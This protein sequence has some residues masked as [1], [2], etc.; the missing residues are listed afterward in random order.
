[1]KYKVKASQSVSKGSGNIKHNKREQDIPTKNI[2]RD[3]S[4]FNVTLID[5]PIKEV[6]HMVFDESVRAYN[7][8][9]KRND[10]KINDYYTKINND[11]KTK[12][13]QELV[14]QVGNR[15]EKL[16]MKTYNQ[17]YEDFLN[18]FNN[19]NPQ[20]CVFGAYIHHDEPN[21]TP[22]L[23]LDYIPVAEYDKGMSKRVA[24][25]RAIRQM[26][27]SDWREWKDR[28]FDL[29]EEV[30]QKHDIQR[31]NMGNKERHMPL[32]V[33]RQLQREKERVREE[34]RKEVLEDTEHMKT[35]LEVKKTVFGKE[36][37]ETD[38]VNDK[39]KALENENELY[40]AQIS[41]LTNEKEKLEKEYKK[42]K[43]KRYVQKNKLLEEINE[44][45]R[46][47]NNKLK[48]E[49]R[50]FEKQVHYEVEYQVDQLTGVYA[51][52]LDSAREENHK[53]K[54]KV[55]DYDEI[56]EELSRSKKIIERWKT[57]INALDKL[58]ED[59]FDM[60][61]KAIINTFNKIV[62][63]M[64]SFSNSKSQEQTY[65]HKPKTIQERMALAKAQAR[66]NGTRTMD[67]DLEDIA[68]GLK[69]DI[70]EHKQEQQ[71]MKDRFNDWG[72][73]R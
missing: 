36:F 11:N 15:D 25:N 62:E 58:F 10:R 43:K 12:T 71:R 57:V 8:R 42:F 22:H 6:Y 19:E 5:E 9:Q 69:N 67:D 1:M 37:Y 63:A 29:L 2:D 49:K 28:Q 41:S 32:D 20:L 26:G 54:E 55:K 24:N 31:R 65:N 34:T 30:C 7:S 66:R 18:R 14:I 13:F 68:N 21:G 16:D 40:K 23:H 60:P 46:M 51:R 52:E 17:I 33:Y 50:D 59:Y 70:Q 72:I 39:I 48:N 44:D 64:D 35:P 4:H 47:E 56:K 73:E 45:L 61:H 53:L 27:Y 3:L 38:T